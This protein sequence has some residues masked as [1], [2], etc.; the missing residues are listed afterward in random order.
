M[1]KK[2]SEIDPEQYVREFKPRQEHLE[3]WRHVLEE[4]E[5][6]EPYHPGFDHIH[7][8]PGLDSQHQ[9]RRYVKAI[10]ILW[11]AMHYK[12]IKQASEL[13]LQRIAQNARRL[14]D[15][16]QHYLVYRLACIGVP[17]STLRDAQD[18]SQLSSHSSVVQPHSI[19]DLGS[20]NSSKQA[21]HQQLVP[22]K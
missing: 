21:D 12:E 22:E 16:E 3:K 18:H 15:Y 10:C 19:E 2:H 8:H 4:L 9:V 11:K 17:I 6:I 14:S 13:V 1:E 20:S 5:K 7:G